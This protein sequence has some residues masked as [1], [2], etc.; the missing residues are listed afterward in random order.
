MPGLFSE[1]GKVM[2]RSE[3]RPENI[4]PFIHS[5]EPDDS[6]SAGLARDI[7]DRLEGADTFIHLPDGTMWGFDRPGRIGAFV[8][9]G[10]AHRIYSILN[11]IDPHDAVVF[12]FQDRAFPIDLARRAAG[13]LGMDD[14]FH[15]IEEVPR[16]L[17]AVMALRGGFSEVTPIFELAADAYQKK[18]FS[19]R[20]WT[21]R[22][23]P[24]SKF[25]AREKALLKRFLHTHHFTDP[26]MKRVLE[27]F[28]KVAEIYAGEDGK[29]MLRRNKRFAIYHQV[30]VAKTLIEFGF[31]NIDS[32]IIPGLAHDILED[33]FMWNEGR[34]FTGTASEA[35]ELQRCYM[36]SLFPCIRPE[37]V[38]ALTKPFIDGTT[39]RD[40][41]DQKAAYFLK[42]SSL[43]PEEC[44]FEC[45]TIK[46]ADRACNGLDFS[47]EE[48]RRVFR[49][50][51]ETEQ[52]IR[53]FLP[54][55]EESPTSL[56]LLKFDAEI[57]FA[58]LQSLWEESVHWDYKPE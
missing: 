9:E 28:G 33:T 52:L 56:A 50:A 29:G 17:A 20:R 3:Y 42:L 37:V 27:A 11:L 38:L 54:L 25:V 32:F 43:N 23:I 10:R 19:H 44:P 45:R 46:L 58:G 53:L 40:K 24:Y 12:A 21:P 57:S 49:Q 34:P 6:L 31:R 8:E 13:K 35:Q 14:D 16:D 2:R 39:I 48:T 5:F 7:H 15:E 1:E 41:D 55:V 51:Q 22:A 26:Q 30:D 36:G 18:F 4:R 47:G